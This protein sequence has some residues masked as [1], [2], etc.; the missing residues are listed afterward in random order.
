M[1]LS[2]QQQP[3]RQGQSHEVISPWLSSSRLLLTLWIFSSSLTGVEGFAQSSSVGSSLLSSSPK[4]RWDGQ[5]LSASTTSPTIQDDSPIIVPEQS[6]VSNSKNNQ[7]NEC[8]EEEEN[9]RGTVVV[10]IIPPGGRFPTTQPGEF[11]IVSY[12]AL[13]PFYHALR[14]PLEERDAALKADRATRVPRSIQTAKQTGAD[15]LCLQEVE[16]G[17]DQ[18][19]TL[20]TLLAERNDTEGYDQCLW[21]ALNPKRVEQ[22]DIV[23]LA[24]AWRSSKFR[25]L[26]QDLYRRGMVVQLQDIV[27]NT[28][29]CVGNVHLPA[30]PA[31]V[32]GRLRFTASTVRRLQQQQSAGAAG[33]A[34]F[35]GDLNC[36]HKA[37]NLRYL[38][39]GY[40]PHGTLRDRNYR[41]RISKK[42]AAAL[43]HCLRFQHAYHSHG[44]GQCAAVTVSL[45][46]RGPGCMDHLY[47]TPNLP[48]KSSMATPFAATP[49]KKKGKRSSRRE[50]AARPYSFL[51]A[52]QPNIQVA[53]L[54]A[55]VDENDPERMKLIRDGLPNESAG[56]YSDHLP[57]GALFVPVA[58]PTR[59][60][61]RLWYGNDTMPYCGPLLIHYNKTFWLPF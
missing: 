29:V 53:A 52:Q 46:G 47:Y 14:L 36:E 48:R 42:A 44:E 60:T 18:L 38:K 7:K 51:S 11:S 16:G 1:V 6:S 17:P 13:A 45:Q 9:A 8:K 39:K 55:T 40:T 22:G 50:R 19:E 35:C 23:G 37:P 4:K 21:T 24:V 28:T 20:Q 15:V 41:M 54:L 2:R 43:S 3:Q 34:I 59:T 12:N 25:R 49:A 10:N 33:P 26:D 5:V 57:V 32:E 58:D 56:F 31:A 61:S 30:R 27:T